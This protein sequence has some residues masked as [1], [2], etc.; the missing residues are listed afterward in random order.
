MATNMIQAPQDTVLSNV[1]P[2]Y[3]AAP[4]SGAPGLVGQIPGVCLNDA[5]EGGNAAGAVDFET[6]G[7]FDLEV[8]AVNN[9]GN[10]AV[11]VGDILYYE[12]GE[13]PPLN[14]DATAVRFGYAL[15]VISS[16]QT[17]TIKVKVGY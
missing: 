2:S 3:P 12:A 1:T 9:G 13:D 16:G 6:A 8:E 7:V 11:A 14:K 17:G 10:S 15:E 5:G 4:T